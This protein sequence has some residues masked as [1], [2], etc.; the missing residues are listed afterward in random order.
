MDFDPWNQRIEIQSN[1]SVDKFPVGQ[2]RP[3][4]KQANFATV[5]LKTRTATGKKA[6]DPER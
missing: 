3:T 4:T 6:I 1:Q 5:L 2:L